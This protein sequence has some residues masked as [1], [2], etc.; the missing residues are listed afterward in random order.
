MQICSAD[1]SEAFAEIINNL[2]R[3]TTELMVHAGF[4]DSYLKKHSFYNTAREKE[5]KA[6]TSHKLK[7]LIKKKN[8]KLISFKD[9]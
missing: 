3:G 9:L 1:S 2:R 5:L 7:I 8:I 4:S 6:L